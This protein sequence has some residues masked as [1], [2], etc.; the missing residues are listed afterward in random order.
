M[1]LPW[2]RGKKPQAPLTASV[3]PTTG[4]QTAQQQPPQQQ[5]PQQPAPPP[6]PAKSKME[7]LNE[8]TRTRQENVQDRELVGINKLHN[9]FNGYK[10]GDESSYMEAPEGDSRL[11]K[12]FNVTTEVADKGSTISG[13]AQKIAKLAGEELEKWGGGNGIVGAAIAF[14][15][16]LKEA[17]EIMSSDDSGKEKAG[18]LIKETA[19]TAFD[20][21]GG[22]MDAIEGLGGTVLKGLKVIPGLGMVIDAIEIGISVYRILKANKARVRMN[23]SRR[24]FKEKYMNAE[25]E[26]GPG[27]EKTKMVQKVGRFNIRRLWKKTD[28]TVDENAMK[29]R[30]DQLLKKRQD[31]P[32]TFTEAE[33]AELMDILSYATQDRL[34]RVNRNKEL[35]NVGKIVYKLGAIA[36]KISAMVGT[37]GGSLAAESAA[38]GIEV[39][40]DATGLVADA[41]KLAKDLY[42]GRGGRDKGSQYTKYLLE[43]IG[44]LPDTYDKPEKKVKYAQAADMIA[45]TS[46]NTNKLYKHADAINAAAAADK[47]QGRSKAFSMFIDLFD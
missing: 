36:A 40:L 29:K 16:Y 1:P 8:A 30:R 31:D 24:L 14:I 17:Y 21:A 23:D 7:L 35:E 6:P 45:A 25:V 13:G 37:F 3:P 20:M 41:G 28:D 47:K 43:I 34:R 19:N 18:K 44:H 10:V 15:Q 46:V 5:P 2:E 22:I 42:N 26:T 9:A 39:A 12:A 11:G 38:S 27:G 33:Q 4:A 32:S